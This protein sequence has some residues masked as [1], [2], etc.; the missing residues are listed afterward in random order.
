[1]S[2]PGGLSPEMMTKMMKDLEIMREKDPDSFL[3]IIK[4]ISPPQAQGGS[5]PQAAAAGDIPAVTPEQ[6]E[7][8]AAMLHMMSEGAGM[9][10][11]EMPGGKTSLGAKGT[12]AKVVFLFLNFLLMII[13]TALCAGSH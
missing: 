4:S 5:A 6:M 8:F 7:A 2:A 10:N 11:L 13:C 12:E 3:N 9:D 1:M